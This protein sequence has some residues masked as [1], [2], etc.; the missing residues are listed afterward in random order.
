M[1]KKEK[2]TLNDEL[3]IFIRKM[4]HTKSKCPLC[5]EQGTVYSPPYQHDPESHFVHRNCKKF[6]HD[7]YWFVEV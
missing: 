2:M 1:T 5:G 7:C 4:E 6:G 3:A